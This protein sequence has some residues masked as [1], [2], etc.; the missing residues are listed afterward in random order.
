MRDKILL[1]PALLLPF[2]GPAMAEQPAPAATS[3]GRCV[4][5]VRPDAIVTL[6]GRLQREEFP[7]NPDAGNGTT[8]AFI[9]QLP[10]MIC[11]EDGK[12][13]DGSERF[14]KVHVIATRPEI[15]AQLTRA[16]GQDITVAGPAMGV[17][18]AHHHAPMV[19]RAETV[20]R[21]GG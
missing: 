5:A 13:A 12:T 17:H 20:T 16:V 15:A 7:A 18:A 8:Q 3:I 1:I 14:D 11:F 21:A 10:R 4:N 6:A 2:A 19:L 9:L